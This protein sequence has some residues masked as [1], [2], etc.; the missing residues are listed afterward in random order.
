MGPSGLRRAGPAIAGGRP[1]QHMTAAPLAGRVE[2]RL[3][4]RPANAPDEV[5]RRWTSRS[6]GAPLRGLDARSKLSASAY[7]TSWM[8]PAIRKTLRK[9]HEG[10][11]I[12]PILLP[13]RRRHIR[14]RDWIPWYSIRHGTLYN[15]RR[16][17]DGPPVC[18]AIR[19]R[20]HPIGD[21][22]QNT[23]QIPADHDIG[24]IM[25]T[26]ANRNSTCRIPVYQ[27]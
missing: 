21:A 9:R 19:W 2:R 4:P 24:T 23:N 17:P 16:N 6:G 7:H 22:C 25:T 5:H 10:I 8:C 20:R 27:R 14:Q 18:D 12:L 3:R 13:R 11:A 26:T 15:P 1:G